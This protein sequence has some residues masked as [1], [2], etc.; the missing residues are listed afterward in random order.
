MQ[1]YYFPGKSNGPMFL[2]HGGF[3][4]TNEEGYFLIAAPLIERGYPVL[5]FEGPGQ[6]SMARDYNIPFT[7]DWHRPPP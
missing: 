7:V 2:V 5:A 3:D 1:A 6:S 4:S